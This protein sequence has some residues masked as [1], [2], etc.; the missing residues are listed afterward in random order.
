MSDEQLWKLMFGATLPRS[1]HVYSNGTCPACGK[2][3]PMYDWKIDAVKEPWKLRCP[4][5]NEA[6]PKNDFK[7]FYD[8]GLDEHG[9]FDPAKADRSLLYNTEHPGPK[10]PLYTF[11]VDDG[12]GYVR[13]NERWRF[14]PYYLVFGQWK[15]V[16]QRGIIALSSAYQLTGDPVYAHKAAILLDRVADVY[17]AFD[18]MKQGIL[19]ESDHGNGYVSVWH[20]ATIETPGRW[21]SPTMRS[22]RRSGMTRNW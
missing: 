2:P 13:G 20:D 7:K 12:A 14:I 5:C 10:D 22:N 8:S 1:W 4:H 17:P 11:G 9:V 6:F 18:F 21:R 15:Q 16:V 3:V 19:Y